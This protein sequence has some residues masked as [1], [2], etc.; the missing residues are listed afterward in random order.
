MARIL[1][2]NV[3]WLGDVIFSSPIFR[4]LRQQ[5]PAAHIACMAVPRVREILECIPE[6]DEI[7]PYDEAGQDKG[8]GAKLRW[9]RQLK[10]GRFDTAYFLS[11]SMSRAILIRLAGIPERIGYENKG[12]GRLLTR[13][14]PEPVQPVHRSDYYLN[15]VE[16]A[17]VVVQDRKTYLHPPPDVEA[18]VRERLT[19]WGLK[20]GEPKI[21]FNPGG[22]WDLKRWPKASFA[23]LIDYVAQRTNAR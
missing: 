22:N 23:R 4:A 8:V 11:R 2:I 10:K 20:T 13:I 18:E 17:G 6:I 1:V 12:R 5:D 19:E 3:N 9:I 15:V 7:I 21:V 14:V 16:S